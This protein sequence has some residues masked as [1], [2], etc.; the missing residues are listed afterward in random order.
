MVKIVAI[1]KKVDKKI[2][3]KSMKIFIKFER[4][5]NNWKIFF[6][7]FDKNGKFTEIWSKFEDMRKTSDKF[8]NLPTS[9]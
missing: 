9:S 8:Y 5:R 2:K 1:I 6:L 7:N 3:K 4:N